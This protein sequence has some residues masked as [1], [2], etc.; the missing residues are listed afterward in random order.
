M[1][2]LEALLEVLI[3]HPRYKP[4]YKGWGKD[5]TVNTKIGS[6]KRDGF[7]HKNK[8]NKNKLQTRLLAV[9]IGTFYDN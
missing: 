6:K 2:S 1:F 4:R 7:R 8:S 9:S 5:V 3:P